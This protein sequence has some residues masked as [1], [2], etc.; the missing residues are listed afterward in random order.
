MLL[1]KLSM[2]YDFKLGHHRTFAH[3][4]TD[5]LTSALR[6]FAR[7]AGGQVSDG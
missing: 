2:R 1:G 7:R 4:K 6:R 3:I 5:Y